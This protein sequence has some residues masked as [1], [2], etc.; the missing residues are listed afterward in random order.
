[1]N[2][3]TQIFYSAKRILIDPKPIFIRLLSFLLIILILGTAFKDQF[4]VTSLDKVRIV[5]SNEDSGQLGEMFISSMIGAKEISSLAEFDQVLSLDEGREI[6]NIEEADAFIYIPEGFSNQGEADGSSKTVEV[7]L[8]KSSGVDTTVVRNVVD[9]LINGLNTAGV[10]ATMSGNTQIDQVN[11]D[12]SLKEEPLTDSKSATAMGYYA[13]AMLLMFMM[14]GQEYGAAGMGE[15]YLGTLGDRLKLSPIKPFEQYLGKTI[16]LSLVTFLQGM[17][18]ILFT[19]YVYDVDWGN[20][21]GVIVLIVFVFSLLT[22]TLGGLLTIII[23]D[24]VKADTLANIVTLVSTF[25]IGGFIIID[26]GAIAAISP[27]YYAKSAIFNV[28]YNDE[29][30]SAFVNI[31]QMLAITLLF[32]VISIVVSRRK[33]A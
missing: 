3:L 16:G 25:L 27:S 19:K 7:F 4:N 9:S 17:V 31:G 1:M 12:T 33:R 28:V 22:T 23:K 18:I 6:L 11:S 26:F 15:D 14:R 13:I 2:I 10:V 21:F 20:H 8:A 30:G 29:L 5:Y 24:S 32:A